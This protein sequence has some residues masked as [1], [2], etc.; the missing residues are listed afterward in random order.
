VH[1]KDDMGVTA[2]EPLPAEHSTESGTSGP[3]EDAPV[4]RQPQPAILCNYHATT[5]EDASNSLSSKR[6]SSSHVEDLRTGVVLGPSTLQITNE[7]NVASISSLKTPKSL[8]LISRVSTHGFVE[9]A[10]NLS[11]KALEALV[12]FRAVLVAAFLASGADS[13]LLL[14]SEKRVQ[15]VQ[16]L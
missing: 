15:V 10:P 4:V 3:D 7:T 9:N 1:S 2:L 5:V 13:T 8:S 16:V 11:M 6:S 12:F 14:K